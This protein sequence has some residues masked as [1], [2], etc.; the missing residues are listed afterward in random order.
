MKLAIW[1]WYYVSRKESTCWVTCRKI[2]N[3]TD[4]YLNLK[5]FDH[6]LNKINLSHR[7]QR[8]SKLKAPSTERMPCIIL[9]RYSWRISPCLGVPLGEMTQIGLLPAMLYYT[10]WRIESDWFAYHINRFFSAQHLRKESSQ[11]SSVYLPIKQGRLLILTC[12]S[13]QLSMSLTLF[14][15]KEHA[16]L[17]PNIC[18]SPNPITMRVRYTSF[19]TPAYQPCNNFTFLKTSPQTHLPSPNDKLIR[20]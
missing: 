9:C 3:S 16:I 8:S 4:S 7:P 17:L 11:S 15:F 19:H 10:V 14:P 13:K 12:T 6:L 20:S 18:C 1:V 2:K 5:D